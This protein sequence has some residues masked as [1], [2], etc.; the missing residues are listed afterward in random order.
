MHNQII[1]MQKSCWLT[2]NHPGSVYV[3]YKHFY[4]SHDENDVNFKNALA[5]H[6]VWG[7][8]LC[9]FLLKTEAK[10]STFFFRILRSE[11]A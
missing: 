4:N 11:N 8:D 3:I 6:K 5:W 7:P 9:W 1:E 10:K 2:S